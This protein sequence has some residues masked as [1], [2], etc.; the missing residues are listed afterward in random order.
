MNPS[1]KI[2]FLAID[3]GDKFLIRNWSKDG[4]LPI[5]HSLFAKGLIGE[6]I[7]VEGFY[8][9]ST[10]PSFYT[11][12]NPAHHGFHRLTQLNPR[13][14]EF[15][16][17]Y[18]GEF[19]SRE[20]FWNH[21]SSAGKKVAILDIPLAG[22][23]KRLN[24]IQMVEWGS[25]D[26]AYGFHTW[27]AGLKR[28]VEKRFGTHPENKSCDANGRSPED[29]CRFRDHL[30]EGVQKK[31]ELTLDYMNQQEWDFFAQVF[32]EGH[33]AGHQCWHLHDPAHP[34]YDR[35]IVSITGDPIREVYKA[36][37]SAIGKI[38]AHVDEKTIVFLLA[39]H[40]MAHNIGAS[41]LLEDILERLNYLKKRPHGTDS[42]RKGIFR[43]LVSFAKGEWEKLP[44]LI[45]KT[46]KPGLFA[47]INLIRHCI[48]RDDF[49]RI[50]S[51]LDIKHCKCFPH[52]NGN[53][54][55]GIRINLIG[56]EPIG[57]VKPGKELDDLCRKIRADLQ[58]IVE[59]DSGKPI[60]N[61]VLRTSDFLQGEYIDHLPD[62]LV[63][64][65]ED[66]LIGSKKMSYDTSYRLQL[67]SD[68]IGM[69]EGEYTYCRT[70]DHRPEGLF[71]VFG[72]G[73]KPGVIERTISIMDFAPT[74]LNIFGIENHDFDGKPISEIF[75]INS[76]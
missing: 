64:W 28:D 68:K 20:P 2:L 40:R 47:L 67:T 54:I 5:M 6:T 53:L 35:N 8:E 52:E 59:K 7:S 73:I 1:T 11:G 66:K 34:N 30:I 61:R 71:M 65:S 10:W 12:V 57:L 3:A 4:T 51:R 44:P 33:C 42:Q 63:E 9:G 50:S 38:L 46:L 49:Y 17:C 43:R 37:D 72:P 15:H 13:T 56:R 74:F 70:G 14:Y 32:T 29:F 27:P 21:L 48:T 60:V 41:F 25:H 75:E 23:S 69:I 39:T 36:I 31:A 55:S 26:A 24:G 22:I 18:P 45:Q 76:F 19:I 62:L 16:R 58:N